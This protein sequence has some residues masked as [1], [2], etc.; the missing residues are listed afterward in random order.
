MSVKRDRSNMDNNNS[1][2]H[3]F[4]ISSSFEAI[5]DNL[6]SSSSEINVTMWSEE[7]LQISF[8]VSEKLYEEVSD[9]KM[10]YSV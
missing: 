7:S 4:S 8:N 6:S 10:F 5:L 1:F 2:L 3:D 9:L